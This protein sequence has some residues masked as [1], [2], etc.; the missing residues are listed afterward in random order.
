MAST[1]NIIK[2]NNRANVTH[3]SYLIYI[4][5]KLMLLSIFENTILYVTTDQF[6]KIYYRQKSNSTVAN[7]CNRDYH[8][9]GNAALSQG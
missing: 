7:K 6:C 9:E 8:T 5:K 2:S 1:H 3:I 4:A